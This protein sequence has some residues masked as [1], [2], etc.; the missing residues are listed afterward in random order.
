MK[1]LA[2]KVFES[3]PYPRVVIVGGGFAGLSLVRRLANKPFKV[4]LVDKNNFH[5]FQPLL[6]QVATASLTPDSIAYPFRKMIGP[7]DNVIF[8]MAKVESVDW[9]AKE[10]VT[11]VGRLPYDILVLATGSTTN[12]F[13]NRDMAAKAMQLKTVGQALDIRSDFLQNFERAVALSDTNQTDEQRKVLHFVIVGGG[14]TGVEVAGA[15]AEIK[16]KILT[17]EY[18]EVDPQQMDITVIDAGPR[19][20]FG[21]SEES[22]ARAKQYLEKLGVGILLDTQVQGYDGETVRLSNGQEIE[23]ETVIWAAGVKG[24]P[25]PGLKEEAYLP[26]GRVLVDEY[27]TIQGHEYVFAL[28]DMAQMVTEAYPKGHPMMAQPA[29]QQADHF[30]KNLL[31]LSR[32]KQP[33]PFSYR[34]KG[35]MATIGRHR[36]V[37]EIGNLKLGGGLAWY[38]W[39][40]VH[41]LFLIGFRNRMAVLFNWAVKYFSYSN[42]IR[43]IV[44]PFVRSSS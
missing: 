21:M 17:S 32:K 6:Y 26:N 8:R 20:L 31:R 29:M 30:A 4:T 14:P 7:M 44:R 11:S 37:A 38:V 22:S 16:N 36:A 28:G 18:R 24:N 39:M 23:T 13:G 10:L 19:L 25:I 43:L 42:T 2:K 3:L 40:G 34:D 15:L 27:N 12:F 5:T 33:L 35:S 41:I 1:T 9:E